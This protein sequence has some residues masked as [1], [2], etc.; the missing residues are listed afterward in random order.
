[1]TSAF[2]WLD[3]DES[4][5][6]KMLEVINLFREKGTL[7]ELGFGVIRD[8]F[9]NYFFP[10]T[11]TIQTRARYFLFL[12]WIYLKLE[13]EGTRAAQ[14]D[15]QARRWQ[16]QLARALAAGGEGDAAGVIGIEAGERLQRPPSVVYWSGMSRW[17]I[18]LLPGS[19]EQYHLSF[20]N[21]AAEARGGLRSDDGEG[22]LVE[23]S[24]RNWHGGLPAAP[25]S[26]FEA[27]TFNLTRDES[28]YLQERILTSVPGS[29]LA[30]MTQGP[31]QI[32]RVDAPWLYPQLDRLPQPLRD[33]VEEARRF[34]LLVIGAQYLYNLMM[35][36]RANQTGIR[37][38]PE[39]IERYRAR[40]DDWAREVK[41][42]IGALRS[43]DRP[44]FW[45]IVYE[46][47]PSLRRS[48]YQF[49]ETWMRMAVEGPDGLP[50]RG[51][52]RGLITSRE[53]AQKGGLARL[54]SQRALER[55]NGASGLGRLTY[56]WPEGRMMAADILDGLAQK[57]GGE[58]A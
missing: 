12:P 2:A 19:L 37:D 14:V 17:G 38:E 34:S 27:T 4:E 7:D 6:R 54:H 52:A 58:S 5:R 23:A 36:E 42:E 29:M 30:Y 26:L 39:L 1:M 43:W 22:E 24:R 20:D 16:A 57:T 33:R 28:L 35:A 51:D 49:A 55:W 11:S 44:G 18:K 50:D 21:L 8:A 31:R 45:S 47:N 9:A 40:L 10:G 32:R 48:A 25:E 13:A 41:Q 3:H 56:R 46:L 53:W 15:Q